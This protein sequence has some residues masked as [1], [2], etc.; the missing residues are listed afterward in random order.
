MK[1]ILVMSALFSGALFCNEREFERLSS[2]EGYELVVYRKIQ[3]GPAEYTAKV[4]FNQTEM[5]YL[6]DCSDD[7]ENATLFKLKCLGGDE[8]IN[9]EIQWGN[10]HTAHQMQGAWTRGERRILFSKIDY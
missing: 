10:A 8:S 5:A 7:Y 3:F 1:L 9:F 6:T 4:F 2:P